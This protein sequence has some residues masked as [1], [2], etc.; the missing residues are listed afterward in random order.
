MDMTISM[1]NAHMMRLPAVRARWMMESAQASMYAHS[2]I[3]DDA[4]A[5]IWNAWIGTITKVTH[6]IR[7]I[8]GTDEAA[9]SLFT[10]NGEPVTKDGLRSM[11]D[12]VFGRK[13]RH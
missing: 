4:R 13:M 1:Y 8:D 10:W 12:K 11:L 3:K 2:Y 6:M 9:K 5:K 7:M